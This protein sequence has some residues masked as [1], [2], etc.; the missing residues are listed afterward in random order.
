MDRPF[1]GQPDCRRAFNRE[2][3]RA[4]NA[5]HPG[6]YTTQP[7][8]ARYREEIQRGER[9]RRRQIYPEAAQAADQRR[10]ARKRGAECE[11]FKSREIFDR[12]GWICG[13]CHEPVDPEVKYPDPRSVSLDHIITLAN[14]G[15]HTRANTRCSHL[16]CNIGRNSSDNSDNS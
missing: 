1:C 7:S 8:R 2:R 11:S 16:S 12:D 6:Y 9:P 5:K 14:G 13:I 10:R 15:P 3:M 4:W